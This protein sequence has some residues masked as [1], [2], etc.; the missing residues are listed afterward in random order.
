MPREATGTLVEHPGKDGTYFA[1]RVRRGDRRYYVSL[2]KVDRGTAHNEMRRAVREIEAGT[3]VP[4]SS[5]AYRKKLARTR[6]KDASG[7]CYVRIRKA[8][9]ACDDALSQT[10]GNAGVYFQRAQHRL[11]EAEDDIIAGRRLL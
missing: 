10:N 8:L 7:E 1:F 4:P 9:E 5:A 11:Y 2:G 6:L 3:W